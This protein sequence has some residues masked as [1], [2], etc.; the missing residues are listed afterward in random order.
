[1]NRTKT[2]AEPVAVVTAAVEDGRL[3]DRKVLLLLAAGSLGLAAC[4]A[5]P[6]LPEFLSQPP[7]LIYTRMLEIM[8][9]S[10]TLLPTIGSSALFGVLNAMSTY[11]MWRAQF[12]NAKQAVSVLGGNVANAKDR[13]LQAYGGE[14]ALDL[15]EFYK[16]TAKVVSQEGILKFYKDRA[17]LFISGV[18]V[19]FTVPVLGWRVGFATPDIPKP[20]VA[21]DVLKEFGEAVFTT[22]VILQ[23]ITPSMKNFIQQALSET[24]Q[25]RAT[26]AILKAGSLGV[27]GVGALWQTLRKQGAH[28]ASTAR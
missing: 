1:M 18:D 20:K 27:L 8:T 2:E 15:E 16:E 19:D 4:S 7:D 6:G 17:G 5:V 25:S 26:I 14:E 21:V 11:N 12:R 24:D 3:I 10:E 22:F 13:L 23:V 28:Q 9:A